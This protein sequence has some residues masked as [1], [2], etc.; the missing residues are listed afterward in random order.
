MDVMDIDNEL[1]TMKKKEKQIN[2]K[3]TEKFKY[4]SQDV[5]EFSKDLPKEYNIINEQLL[6]IDLNKPQLEI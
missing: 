5:T 4:Y 1:N 2:N 6:N 3:I